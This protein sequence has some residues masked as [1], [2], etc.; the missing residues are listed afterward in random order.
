MINQQKRID[1]MNDKIQELI[2]HKSPRLFN[3]LERIT[4]EKHH[5]R[6]ILLPPKYHDEWLEWKRYWIGG[7]CDFGHYNGAFIEPTNSVKL[8]TVE[9]WDLDG[10]KKDIFDNNTMCD[11]FGRLRIAI[12]ISFKRCLNSI[13]IKTKGI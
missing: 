1:D 8:I 5:I 7:Y 4:S 10:E 13:G 3:F 9:Y 2:E 12:F 11:E 6:R